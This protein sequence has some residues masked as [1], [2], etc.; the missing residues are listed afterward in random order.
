MKKKI[1][2]SL[3]MRK[4]AN[5][6]FIYLMILKNLQKIMFTTAEPIGKVK[7]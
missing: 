2:I 3:E 1:S 4:E 6:Y 5:T 7:T